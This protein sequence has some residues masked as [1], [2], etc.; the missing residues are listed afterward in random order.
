VVG[1][2]EG[3]EPRAYTKKNFGIARGDRVWAI[4]GQWGD[5]KKTTTVYTLY[6]T[7]IVDRIEVDSFA[8]H[9]NHYRGKGAR[10]IDVTLNGV[11]WFENFR[12]QVLG[13]A[14]YSSQKLKDPAVIRGL[15][16]LAGRQHP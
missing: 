6:T 2:E 15:G 11:D 14:H 1:P 10:K 9:P 13:P 16:G 3:H 5:N 8:D 4:A 7:S 12:K